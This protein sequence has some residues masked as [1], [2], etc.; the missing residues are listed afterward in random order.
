MGKVEKL[1]G[2]LEALM[3]QDHAALIEGMREAEALA[4]TAAPSFQLAQYAGCEGSPTLPAKMV[5]ASSGG[6][7]PPC[8]A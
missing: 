7:P 2:A 8:C 6:L 5:L 3:A 1:V 4:N